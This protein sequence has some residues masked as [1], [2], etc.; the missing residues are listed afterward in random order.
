[1]TICREMTCGLNTSTMWRGWKYVTT[2]RKCHFDG[3]TAKSINTDIDET[4]LF[5]L[6]LLIDLNIR[7]MTSTR[8]SNHLTHSHKYVVMSDDDSHDDVV[9]SHIKLLE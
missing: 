9:I 8:L 6:F 2:T 1:M 7:H 4:C 3:T 5:A